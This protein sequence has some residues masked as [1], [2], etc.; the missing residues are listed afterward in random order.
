MEINQ[1]N[2]VNNQTP[3]TN[4]DFTSAIHFKAS[5]NKNELTQ[6]NI[7]ELNK[8]SNKIIN[9]N[10]SE[11]DSTSNQHI[12]RSNSLNTNSINNSKLMN[13]LSTP[14]SVDLQSEL[15]TINQNPNEDLGEIEMSKETNC[16]SLISSNYN[17]LN[18]NNKHKFNIQLNSDDKIAQ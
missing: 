8:L 9:A 6:P 7:N 17:L 18:K 10:N 11:S 4:I 3:Q 13:R 2:V 14:V 12:N 16:L 1:E 15:N 5:P